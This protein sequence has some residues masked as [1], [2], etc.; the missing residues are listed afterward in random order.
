M[1][2]GPASE[3]DKMVDLHS[4]ICRDLKAERLAKE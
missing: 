3:G 2:K 1:L 4:P